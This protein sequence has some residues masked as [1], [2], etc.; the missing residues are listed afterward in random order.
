MKFFTNL[1]LKLKCLSVLLLFILLLPVDVTA[2]V[3]EDQKKFY[4]IL[5]ISNPIQSS[6]RKE[7]FT[8]NID[9]ELIINPARISGNRILLRIQ[10]CL[11]TDLQSNAGGV[12]STL[13]RNTA[14]NMQHVLKVKQFY[15]DYAQIDRLFKSSFQILD[16]LLQKYYSN[17]EYRFECP[18]GRVSL[19]R[20]GAELSYGYN[21][22]HMIPRYMLDLVN[23]SG[24]YGRDI[25][26]SDV[27]A[28]IKYDELLQTNISLAQKEKDKKNEYNQ[29]VQELKALSD[30]KSSDYT[31]ELLFRVSEK[32]ICTTSQDNGQ[33]LMGHAML[34][35]KNNNLDVDGKFFKVFKNIESAYQAIKAKNKCSHFIDYPENIFKLHTALNR[36]KVFNKV[37]NKVESL[38]SKKI[39]VLNKGYKSIEEYDLVW[40]LNIKKELVRDL[41]KYKI[42]SVEKYNE[43]QEKMLKSTYSQSKNVR[44]VLS[45]LSDLQ[46]A[47]KKGIDILKQRDIRLQA[48]KKEREARAAEKEKQ[49]IAYAKKY[50]YYAVLSCEANGSHANIAACFSGGQYGADTELT[51]NGK[52][53]KAYNI[54]QA[55]RENSEGLTFDLANDFSV[56]AQNANDFLILKLVI[57]NRL[58]DKIVYQKEVA[59]YGVIKISD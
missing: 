53:Y 41:A 23:A 4:D 17:Y 24:A 37:G 43:I 30:K 51:L 34:L 57:T 46:E 10:N 2:E 58:T 16:N 52:I 38:E 54:N 33:S 8:S 35:Q 59:Q 45:Y 32:A 9:G 31:F 20:A 27:F 7:L 29:K 47:R 48:L 26:E 44:D 12:N 50:P 6:S 56:V 36:D 42:D 22:F 1:F 40:A 18:L 14:E 21:D 49:K 39:Y 5:V 13:Y 25:E 28:V 55:G 3:A 11:L 15:K 19:N